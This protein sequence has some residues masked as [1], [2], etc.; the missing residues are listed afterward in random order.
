MKFSDII[1]ALGLT[2]K[3]LNEARGTLDS[4]KATLTAVVDMF[5]VAGLDLDTLLAA[6]PDALKAHLDGL[7]SDDDTL[8]EVLLECKRLEAELAT[9]AEAAA[10][11]S[12]KLTTF[13]D[14]FYT[15]GVSDTD[16]APTAE[17]LKTAFADHVAKQVTLALAKTGHP[18]VQHL[19]ATAPATAPATDAE[20]HATWKSLAVGSPE[21]VAFL[22]KHQSAIWRHSQNS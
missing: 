14:I 17:A 6:G 9:S 7:A 16:P 20:L 1:A 8:A 11:N 21:R 13:S 19:D 15:L 22:V 12:G 4:S 3:T 2:P 5:S 10:L 18:P